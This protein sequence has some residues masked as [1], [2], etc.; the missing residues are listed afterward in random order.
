[1]TMEASRAKFKC[2]LC[3]LRFL[4]ENT[5]FLH[6]QN[7]HKNSN[8]N[9]QLRTMESKVKEKIGGEISIVVAPPVVS[10][11]VSSPP[12]LFYMKTKPGRKGPSE[13]CSQCSFSSRN[14]LLLLEHR[15]LEHRVK[16]APVFYCGYSTCWF[17]FSSKRWRDDHEKTEHGRL[18][19]PPFFCKICRK[20]FS[21]WG[22]GQRKHYELCSKKV[23]YRCPSGQACAYRSN[24]SYSAKRYADLRRHLELVHGDTLARFRKEQYEVRAGGVEVKEEKMEVKTETESRQSQQS[25]EYY[26]EE[27]EQE[28][29]KKL[30][31]LAE[32]SAAVEGHFCPFDQRRFTTASQLHLHL[33]SVH[34]DTGTDSLDC[35]L[36]LDSLTC[37]CGR[38]TNCRHSLVG[39]VS[40]C[41][42]N[43]TADGLRTSV[44]QED[45]TEARSLATR[46]KA[47]RRLK[48]LGFK[49]QASQ[50]ER[51]RKDQ[52]KVC[53]LIISLDQEEGEE[54]E[55]ALDDPESKESSEEE[56]EG[57]SQV[58]LSV[59]A[60][61]KRKS[62]GVVRVRQSSQL[63][64]G[65]KH[66]SSGDED[67]V[68]GPA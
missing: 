6:T 26:E 52:M 22:S 51:L 41:E 49:N 16:P 44:V 43:N 37:F 10:P 24:S 63:S 58:D 13:K 7:S 29:E 61:V 60:P 2:S 46:R 23:V 14:P 30:S 11:L 64:S 40:R 45:N 28:E 31:G 21:K 9:L 39:H 38:R 27:G 12:D 56:E 19:P 67:W 66:K 48:E 53:E 34:L 18:A 1:M 36:G 8:I 35:P 3:G 59:L 15:S 68:S 50:Q 17:P 4:F 54:T 20:R 25:E 42:L 5:L 65:K 33:H 62:C 57:E 32:A 55:E 47:A